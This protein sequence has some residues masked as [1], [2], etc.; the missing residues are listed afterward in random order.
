MFK[1]SLEMLAA[2]V[3]AAT[4]LLAPTTAMADGSTDVAID[5]TKVDSSIG[6]QNED[7]LNQVIA[8]DEALTLRYDPING[9]LL[10]VT[11]GVS[12]I[13]PLISGGNACG[14]TDVCLM[15]PTTP[16]A[17]HGFR[18]AGTMNGSWTPISA[19]STGQWS[20]ALKWIYQFQTVQGAKVG[21]NKLVL[22]GTSVNV[23]QVR[24]Y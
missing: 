5:G 12:S 21:P 18:G 8:S 2:G 9:K 4:M 17:N 1:K 19:Y 22:F 23:T 14:A 11:A 3:I 15:P 7:D 16:Y 6:V 24:I 20:A 10:S 13:S